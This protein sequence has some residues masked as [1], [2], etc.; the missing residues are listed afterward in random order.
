[1]KGLRQA[2]IHMARLDLKI[3]VANPNKTLWS[4]FVT[5]MFF[6]ILSVCLL[7]CQ[8]PTSVSSPKVRISYFTWGQMPVETQMIKNLI[9]KFEETHPHIEVHY[10]TA[11][12]AAY[13]QKLQT[14]GA[15]HSLPDV[16]YVQPGMFPALV[17]KDIF[18]NLD[19]Y[20]Q[21]TPDFDFND[22]YPIATERFYYKGHYYGI[23][24]AVGPNVLYFNKTMFDACGVGYP[25][26]DWTWDD[27]LEACVKLTRDTN[28]DG[29]AD[30]WG[31]VLGDWLSPLWQNGGDLLSSDGSRCVLD[32][33]EAVEA[34]E[35]YV[36]L[37][38]RWRVTVDPLRFGTVGM[39]PMD[40]FT[41]GRVGMMELGRYA[42]FKLRTI[43][44]FEWDAAPLPHQRQR[45]TVIA[46]L[47]WCIS[48]YTAHPRE[49]WEFVRFLASPYAFSEI[50]RMGQVVP[51]R[52]SIAE[53]PIFLD[54]DLPPENDQVFLDEIGYGRFQPWSPYFEEIVFVVGQEL[55]KSFQNMKSVRQACYD[56]TRRINELLKRHQQEENEAAQNATSKLIS[57]YLPLAMSN[58]PVPFVASENRLRVPLSLYRTVT[59]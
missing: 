47:G 27:F 17:R 25:N 11:P 32:A 35:F 53:S 54:P 1:M 46:G 4:S 56:A 15:A 43:R 2:R 20:I 39:N 3:P 50:T 21:E 51:P 58:F 36:G 44:G 48:T 55:D 10:I 49:A 59:F 37:R 23:P 24:A 38:N 57:P 40:L 18:L 34:F 5:I 30:Q 16:F 45:A 9:R 42:L 8:S 22:F 29:I 7:T 6:T 33:P 28:G 52:R 12:A 19:P 31:Y 14:L 41:A 13:Y 26:E